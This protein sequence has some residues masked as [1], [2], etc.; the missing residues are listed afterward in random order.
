MV[1]SAYNF[2]DD[3]TLSSFAKTMGNLIST[4]QSESEITINWFKYNHTIVNPVKF[5][6]QSPIKAKEIMQTKL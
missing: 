4:L 6:Q 1:A 5:K 3:N 2:A